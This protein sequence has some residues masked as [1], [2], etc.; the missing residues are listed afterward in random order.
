MAEATASQQSQPSGS[1]TYPAA[2]YLPPPG[3]Y[4]DPTIPAINEQLPALIEDRKSPNPTCGRCFKPRHEHPS[5]QQRMWLCEDQCGFCGDIHPVGH[6]CPKLYA[7]I[8]W[9]KDRQRLA[10]KAPLQP[11][12]HIRPHTKDEEKLQRDGYIQ[13]GTKTASGSLPVFT[14]KAWALRGPCARSVPATRV[15]NGTNTKAIARQM[16]HKA[17]DAV[18]PASTNTQNL[19]LASI[20]CAPLLSPIGTQSVQHA[21]RSP[22]EISKISPGLESQAS[23]RPQHPHRWSAALSSAYAPTNGS[24]SPTTPIPPP[25]RFWNDPIETENEELRR[26]IRAYEENEKLQKQLAAIEKSHQQKLGRQ[27][28]LHTGRRRKRSES[29]STVPP[30]RRPRVEVLVSRSAMTIEGSDSLT[31]AQ[32]R[33]GIQCHEMSGIPE[34]VLHPQGSIGPLPSTGSKNH[35]TICESSIL[36]NDYYSTKCPHAFHKQCVS[37]LTGLSG[38]D[39]CPVCSGFYRP[40]GSS[41]RD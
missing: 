33:T 30:A 28:A 17:K 14:A 13:R 20:S 18:L 15:F 39:Q 37:L 9:L 19:E 16:H 12:T 10:P 7:S 31:P 25:S 1:T 27:E 2:T 41:E 29:P 3:E 6:R 35:C 26:K 32:L 36:P 21:G 24:A 8:G 38:Q 5:D 22:L 34:H 11:Q 40:D 23:L 4:F